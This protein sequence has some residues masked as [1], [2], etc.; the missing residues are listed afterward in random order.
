MVTSVQAELVVQ[1]PSVSPGPLGP[2]ELAAARKADPP[3][4]W[5]VMGS[6]EQAISGASVWDLKALQVVPDT[7]GYGS[8]LSGI[9]Y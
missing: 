3:S 9:F 5:R 1:S 6:G 8:F 7:R 2:P 4:D